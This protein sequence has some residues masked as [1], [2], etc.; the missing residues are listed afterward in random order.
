MSFLL[1]Y[2]ERNTVIVPIAYPFGGL[3][4]KD[5]DSRTIAAVNI[6]LF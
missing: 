2:K 4:Q 5:T 1:F 3:V 6:V